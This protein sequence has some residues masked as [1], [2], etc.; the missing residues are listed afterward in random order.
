MI[1]KDAHSSKESDFGCLITER[2]GAMIIS[3]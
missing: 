3:R 2:A 1:Q